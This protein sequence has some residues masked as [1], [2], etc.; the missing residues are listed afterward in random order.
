[1]VEVASGRAVIG[2]TPGRL[3]TLLEGRAEGVREDFLHESPQHTVD[4]PRFLVDRCEVTNAQYLLFLRDAASIT[5]EVSADP[6]ETLLGIAGT[7]F[8]VEEKY[9]EQ[10]D[11]TWRQLYRANQAA[12]DEALPYLL[13]ADGPGGIDAERTESAFRTVSLPPGLP[14]RFIDRRPPESWPELRPP[15]GT[16]DLPVTG[17]SYDDAAAFAEWAGKH[18]P[19]EIE[20]EYAARG[21]AGHVYPWG[22]DWSEGASRANGGGLV[23]PA[24]GEPVLLPVDSLPAG[25]SWCGA[26]HMLGNVAEW[27]SSWFTAYPGSDRNHMSMGAFVKVIRGASLHDGDPLALRLA[28]RDFQ[29]AGTRAPPRPGNRFAGVGFRCAWY[30]EPGRSRLAAVEQRVETW[31]DAADD[32]DDDDDAG[33]SMKSAGLDYERYA[34]AVRER[35]A[36]PDAEIAHHVTVEGRAHAI[37]VVPIHR[38]ELAWED[39]ARRRSREE[40]LQ[41]SWFQQIPIAVLYVDLPGVYARPRTWALV[42][43]EGR[44]GLF[45]LDG[46]PVAY[47]TDRNE[48]IEDLVY[49]R[50]E[51][52]A[53]PLPAASLALDVEEDVITVSAEAWLGPPTAGDE[54]VLGVKNLELVLPAYSL[55]HAPGWRIHARRS[56]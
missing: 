41:A 53:R 11:V 19:T 43:V 21:P 12:L 16:L 52:D 3:A 1:M 39:P 8:D 42:L 36:S 17:V 48:A 29:G 32:S 49:E 15:P 2:T 22:N 9:W 54:T 25:A 45:S 47:L 30:E 50:R 51:G 10:D 55:P 4:V 40:V 38:I 33:P 5:H 56:R 26:H 46:E 31:A 20:W 34:A 14:L 13:V 27:T 7:L 23:D 44:L 28:A 35:F 6:P 18:V 37:V 24:G